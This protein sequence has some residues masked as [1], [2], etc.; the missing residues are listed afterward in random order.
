ML[1]KE[2]DTKKK[3]N[4]ETVRELNNQEF[5]LTAFKSQI[6]GDLERFILVQI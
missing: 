6:F 3:N 2:V 5:S 4:C 1:K